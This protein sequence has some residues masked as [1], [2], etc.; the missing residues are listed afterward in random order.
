MTTASIGSKSMT[1][2]EAIL[3]PLFVVLAFLCMVG[4]A[5]AHDGSL[6]LSCFVGMHCQPDDGVH[7]PQSLL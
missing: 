3:A 4:A 2:G 1:I 5:L 6:C 7:D